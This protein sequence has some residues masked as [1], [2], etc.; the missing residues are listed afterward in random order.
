VRTMPWGREEVLLLLDRLAG[1]Q[2]ARAAR[3]CWRATPSTA[4]GEV[5]AQRA[6]I[7]SRRSLVSPS[8][9]LMSATTLS[10]AVHFLVR[11]TSA[12]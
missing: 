12:R 3:G 2:D 9:L 11:I 1:T 7:A 4:S 8:S 10:V 6:P 5:T